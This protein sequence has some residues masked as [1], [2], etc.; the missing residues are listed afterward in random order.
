MDSM[1]FLSDSVETLAVVPGGFDTAACWLEMQSY[2]KLDPMNTAISDWW[3]IQSILFIIY[4]SLSLQWLR[5]F[6][7]HADIFKR[8]R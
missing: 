6:K 2:Q 7:D 1:Y 3:T 5:C 8:I 4:S